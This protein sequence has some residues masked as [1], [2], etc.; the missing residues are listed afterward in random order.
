MLI[1]LE[2]MNA[3]DMVRKLAIVEKKASVVWSSLIHHY[4]YGFFNK[5]IEEEFGIEP[6][7][8]DKIKS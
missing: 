3:D 8:L 1:S 5:I 7:F 4:G 6:D 2:E